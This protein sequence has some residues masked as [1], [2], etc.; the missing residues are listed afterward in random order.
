[1]NIV[2]VDQKRPCVKVSLE[3]PHMWHSFI[4]GRAGHNINSVMKETCT[5]IHFPDQNRIAGHKKSN[6]VECHP[7]PTHLSSFFF[8]LQIFNYSIASGQDQFGVL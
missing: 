3:V 2:I 8:Y 1:M 4:I 6:Q 7:I 5:K